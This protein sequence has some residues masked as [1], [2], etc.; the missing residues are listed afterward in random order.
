MGIEAYGGTPLFDREGGVL[1]LIVALRRRPFDDVAAVRT[2]LEIFDDRVAAELVR[3][4]AERALTG[5]I[6]FERLVGRISSDLILAAPAELDR[7]LDQALGELGRFAEADRAYVFQVSEDGSLLDNTH[8]WCAEGIEPQIDKLQGFPFDDAL[9]FLRTIKQFAIVDYPSVAAL[10]AEALADRV[11]LEE[12]SIRSVLG[13][14]M[15]VDGRVRGFI[16]LDAVRSERTWTDEDKTLMALVGNAFSG[17]IERKRAHDGLLASEA[18]Y[19]SVVES[20][21][22]VIF[23]LDGAGRW[24]FLNK[25]VGR[26]HRVCTGGYAGAAISS[27]MYTRTIA[28]N[29][30]RWSS[31]CSM[32]NWS[33]APMRHATAARGAASAGWR[34]SARR[35]FDSQGRRLGPVGHAE[36]HHPAKGARVPPRVHRALRRAHRAAQPGPAQRPH[37]ARHGAGAPAGPAARARLHRSRRL[38]GDQRHPGPPGR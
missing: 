8:E 6:A 21:R 37:A 20:V 26:S 38:Q 23:Q 4:R 17:V 7:H 5:R 2:L 35:A 11:L 25:A 15:V 9:L 19:R 24:T 13:V 32:A 31:R 3:E 22:E 14:P 27:C 10:P 36:R 1:G 28:S 29:T 18:R 34:C 33:P 30:A 12:Q 16:G